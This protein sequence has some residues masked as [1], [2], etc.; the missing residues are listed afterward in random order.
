[1]DWYINYFMVVIIPN[2]SMSSSEYSG[3]E[4]GFDATYVPRIPAI[5]AAFETPY[6]E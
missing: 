3:T 1:M 4:P 5:E 6:P 2:F